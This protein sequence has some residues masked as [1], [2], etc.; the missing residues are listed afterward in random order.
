MELINKYRPKTFEQ[1]IG[2]DRQVDALQSALEK[3]KARTVLFVGPS[4]VGKTTLARIAATQLGE[5]ELIEVNAASD[6]GIDDMRAL[7]ER[8][9]YR[10]LNGESRVVIVDEF[11]G[12]SKAAV[13][14]WLKNL[15]E[16]AP[17]AYWFLCTT[18]YAKIPDN[19]RTRCLRIE[20]RPLRLND[21]M[22]LLADVAK[23]EGLKK[24]SA[25]VVALCAEEA[26]GS[27]RQA[28]SN[29]AICGQCATEEEAADLLRTV[30]R[31]SAEAVELA[32]LLVK[33]TNLK[34]VWAL[35][36]KLKEANPE[37][38]RRILR[39]YVSKVALGARN[40][41]DMRYFA[42]L[43]RVFDKPFDS[44]DG[45]APLIIACERAVK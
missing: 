2:H 13:Q 37:S 21:L 35:L 23:K 32:R 45:M 17:W 33:G 26:H 10:P 39:A 18:D 22:A 3:G 6:T 40:E 42:H 19:V 4:G 27:P 9:S 8:C 43:L 28:L 1:V 24:V 12:L 5:H 34:T 29:F 30:V 7:M 38:V 16:P 36:N 25:D 20:L 15:E 11:Q 41:N 31:E 14:S 44:G